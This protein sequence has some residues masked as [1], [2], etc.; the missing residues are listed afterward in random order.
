MRQ[1]DRTKRLRLKIIAEP[2]KLGAQYPVI[3]RCIVRHD[4]TV[5]GHFYDAFGYFKEFGR[6]T[7]HGIVDPGELYH[8]RLNGYLRVDKAD[9]LIHYL[10]SVKFVDG[11]FGD[12]FFVELASGGFYVEYAVNFV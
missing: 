12:A 8:E 6:R 7:Q 4:H 5:T 1:F 9:E 10:L 11:N 3:E 2:L